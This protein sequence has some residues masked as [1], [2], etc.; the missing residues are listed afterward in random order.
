MKKILVA[1]AV[2][3]AGGAVFFYVWSNQAVRT[4][5][6]KSKQEVKAATT[7]S[8]YKD[9]QNAYLQTSIP[10]RFV[11]KTLDAPAS[12]PRLLQQLYTESQQNTRSLFGDQLAITITM[13][14]SG[15][16][17][18]LSDMR[19]RLSHSVYAKI[20]TVLPNVFM[21]EKTESPYELSAFL[22]TDTYA[23]SYVI[24]G[25]KGSP[26]Q[27]RSELLRIAT[28]TKWQ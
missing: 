16:I 6:V 3:A 20:P 19:L 17:T 18:E 12:A 24:T 27:L 26:Q 23:V 9:I 15:G 1:L 5:A 21:F 22:Y 28:S 10:E 8:S 13:L 11:L 4:T 25:Q 14:E 2:L 7:E